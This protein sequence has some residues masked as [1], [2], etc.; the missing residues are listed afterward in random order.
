MTICPYF[1]HCSGCTTQN[2]PYSKQLENKKEN[3]AALLNKHTFPF[4]QVFFGQEFS[5]RN[6]M[7]FIFHSKGLGLRAKDNPKRIIDIDHCPISMPKINTLLTEVRNYFSEANNFNINSFNL[8]LKRGLFRGVVIRSTLLGDSSLSF[9]L[10][11]DISERGVAGEKEKA[12]SQ[13]K[14]FS[15]KTTAKNV[16]ITF[17]QSNIDDLYSSNYL[18]I[19]GRDY[20]EEELCG[21]KFSFPIQGF[22]QN[23]PKVAEKMFNYVNTLL[24]KYPTNNAELMDL[25]SGVGTFG[26]VS[27]KLF[28]KTIF[29]ES[30]SESVNFSQKNMKENSLKN[31]SA[32]ILQ[33]HQLSRLKFSPD[34][35][36]IADPPRAGMEEKAIIQLNTLKPKVIVY[37]SCNPQQLS[38]DLAKFKQYTIKSIALFDL[39]PHTWHSE[40]VVEL[41][42][43]N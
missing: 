24:Q 13:I 9:V 32:H 15:L 27:S 38:K 6:R 28:S 5:Y 26:I 16:V 11:E 35:Y 42:R 20:L 21:K 18:V 2:I 25:Y 4:I 30:F 23:N 19:K 1:D 29:V 31:A 34:L 33:A 12:M 22:F 8:N 36:V 43:K 40:V 37:V 14:E 41:E 17:V 10:N 3:L 39:F 7:E